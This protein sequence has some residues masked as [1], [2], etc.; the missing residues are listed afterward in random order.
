M[1][2]TSS[3]S[4]KKNRDVA[5]PFLNPELSEDDSDWL[6]ESDQSIYISESKSDYGG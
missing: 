4:N 2:P 3:D 5:R 6:S 1:N